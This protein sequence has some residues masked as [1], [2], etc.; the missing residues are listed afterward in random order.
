MYFQNQET[1][2]SELQRISKSIC[3][4]ILIHGEKNCG[5]TYLARQYAQ[6]I[7]AADFI[8][9]DSKMLD[10]KEMISNIYTITSDA[11]VCIENLDCGVDG[12]AQ[13]MLKIFEEP[14]SNIRIII[15][16]RDIKNVPATILGR[17]TSVYVKQFVFDDILRYAKEK[18]GLKAEHMKSDIE[19]Y[20]KSPSDVDFLMSL[21]DQ[22][23]EHLKSLPQLVDVKTPINTIIWKMQS[24]KDGVKIPIDYII[25]SL[26]HGLNARMQK[27]VLQ[28]EADIDSGVPNHVILSAMILNMKSVMLSV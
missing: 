4:S 18:Y 11:V 1:A 8:T 19:T 9:V 21:S 12:V 26:Y 6:M 23:L 22:D 17:C 28:Y 7:K 24:F 16:A 20:C 2:L 13:A 10:I 25:R 15:T 5:K 3:R 27:I 14:P